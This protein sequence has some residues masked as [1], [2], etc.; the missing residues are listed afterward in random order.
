MLDHSICNEVATH[1]H[2]LWRKQ[3]CAYDAFARVSAEALE[4]TNLTARV[5]PQALRDLIN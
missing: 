5:E 2:A 1:A 3:D 4:H